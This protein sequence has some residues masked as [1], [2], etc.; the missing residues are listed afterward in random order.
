MQKDIYVFENKGKKLYVKFY[1]DEI[2]RF[3]YGDKI[4]ESITDAVI[5][6]PKSVVVEMKDNFIKK[7]FE[8]KVFFFEIL[9]IIFFFTKYMIFFEIYMFFSYF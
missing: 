5:L 8:K 1:T 2:V 9:N 6:K 4:K 7:T 3:F